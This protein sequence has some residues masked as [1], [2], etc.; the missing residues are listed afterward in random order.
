MAS[1][2][3][4]ATPLVTALPS[5]PPWR[6]LR[7][8]LLIVGG[9]WLAGRLG[10]MLAIP[11]GYATAIWP[12]AGLAV[13]ALLL[14]GGRYWPAVALGSTLLN[15]E[16]ALEVGGAALPPALLVGGAIGIGAGLQAW[17]AQALVRR[18]VG[19]PS[20]LDQPRD[21]WLFMLLAGPLGCLLNGLWGSA[22][23][24][25]AGQISWAQYPYSAWTWWVGD[26]IG[27]LVLTPL[28][29]V[30]LL[31][32]WRHRLLGMALPLTM[33]YLAVVVAFVYVSRWEQ[34]RLQSGFEE[35]ADQFVDALTE[36][37]Q[38][39]ALVAQ[40]VAAHLQAQPESSFAAFQRFVEPFQRSTAGVR[41]FAW[42]PLL[43]PAEREAFVARARREVRG[44]YFIWEQAG[45][46]LRRPRGMAESYAPVLYLTPMSDNLGVFGFDP[47][48]DPLRRAVYRRARDEG[49]IQ[50]TPPLQ[51]V[52]ERR[53]Q[54]GAIFLAP[55][56]RRSADSLVERRAAIMGYVAVAWRIGDMLQAIEEALDEGLQVQIR[57]ISTSPAEEMLLAGEAPGLHPLRWTTTLAVGG[58][59]W[60]LRFA[61]TA[62]FGAGPGAW[63][64]WAVLA[65]GLMLTATLGMFLLVVTGR[66]AQER[67]RMLE[68]LQR[69]NAE[70]EQFAYVASHD[71]QEP[72]RTVTSYVELLE[73][74]LGDRLS[75]EERGFMRVAVQG[76]Q[77]MQNLIRDLLAYSRVNLDADRRAAVDLGVVLERVR[78]A[79]AGRIA[80]SGATISVEGE[81]PLPVVWADELQMT[82]VLQNLLSNA[83]KYRRADL[84]PTVR[85]RVAREGRQWHLQ[86]CDNGIGFPPAEAS[87]LF[88][89][90]HRVQPRGEYEGTGIGLAIVKKIVQGHGGRI[91]AHSDAEGAIFHLTLPVWEGEHMGG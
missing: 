66:A 51:L 9:Y 79:L 26:V 31:P 41:A 23:L 90:F 73:E 65:I 37:L 20:T 5:I 77:R 25:L 12:A 85:I 67:E 28:L 46:G 55:A 60:E 13:A 87:R 44:D 43:G 71:L 91:W 29:L 83:L 72:L 6:L 89:P 19:W 82:Q 10:L 18:Y 86:V 16:V 74:E 27:V 64:A 35:Q 7:N 39:Y 61:S 36:E 1:T 11:P 50:L 2:Q 52:Q 88:E 84:A 15:V 54:G 75:G 42:L 68:E 40:A 8:L 53:A 70:L 22:V 17:L 59:V 48:S 4:A 49:E 34:Q 76:A 33:L 81:R 63:Q 57:D 80:E 3:L 14:L 21:V 32:S 58:R 56:Y 47:L 24:A 38:Q 69:S 78:Q 62:A 45:D 30:A